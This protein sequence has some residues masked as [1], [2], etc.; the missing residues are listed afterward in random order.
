MTVK[1][2]AGKGGDVAASVDFGSTSEGGQSMLE[3]VLTAGLGPSWD[4]NLQS[5]LAS[6]ALWWSY[7][8]PA[9]P[10]PIS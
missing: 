10:A 1:G 2:Q 6:T 5:L 3:M 9:L 4:F 8:M 7:H